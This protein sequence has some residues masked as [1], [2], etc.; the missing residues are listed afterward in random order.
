MNTR[1]RQ[2]LALTLVAIF[3]LSF[4]PQE[5]SAI[6]YKLEGYLKDYNGAPIPNAN[7]SITGELYDMGVQDMVSIT[8]YET[9]DQQGH[10]VIY[11]AANEPGGFFMDSIMTVSYLVD[12]VALASN[13]AKIQGLGVWANLTYEKS[14]SPTDVF[15]SPIGVLSI[16]FLTAILLIAYFVL[17]SSKEEK[18]KENDDNPKRVER[19]RNK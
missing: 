16:V 3:L 1:F 2:I 14:T 10:Y 13:T 17:R 5:A 18:I 9:T 12:G 11:L 8:L 4:T 19:R 6:P 15:K 7:I